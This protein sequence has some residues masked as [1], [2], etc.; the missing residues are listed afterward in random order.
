MVNYYIKQ[1]IDKKKIFNSLTKT[2]LDKWMKS[3]KIQ[4]INGEIKIVSCYC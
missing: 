1:K 4:I 3:L 2:E